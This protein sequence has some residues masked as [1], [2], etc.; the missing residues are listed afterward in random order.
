M[1]RLRWPF[2]PVRPVL[3]VTTAIDLKNVKA[4]MAIKTKMVLGFFFVSDLF[5]HLRERQHEPVQTTV[6]NERAGLD[7]TVTVSWSRT[8][9]GD[10][11]GQMMGLLRSVV[12]AFFSL[13][14]LK[15]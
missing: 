14:L 9:C 6:Q 15:V 3:S 12:S 4:D 5:S 2:F 13:P 10:E 1:G 11:R 8:G 7:A